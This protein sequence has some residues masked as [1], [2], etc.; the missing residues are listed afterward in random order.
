[1]SETISEDISQESD[2][3]KHILLYKNIF[4]WVRQ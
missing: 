1:M 4:K 2:F 3:L